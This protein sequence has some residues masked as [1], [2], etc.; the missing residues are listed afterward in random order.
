[1]G[2]LTAIALLTSLLV[3]SAKGNNETEVS[4]CLSYNSKEY[5]TSYDTFNLADAKRF[6]NEHNSKLA[7]ISSERLMELLKE[8]CLSSSS[9]FEYPFMNYANSEVLQLGAVAKKYEGFKWSFV[10]ASSEYKALCETEKCI[11]ERFSNEICF[12]ISTAKY[13]FVDAE[14]YCINQGMRLAS[15]HS[16]EEQNF[17]KERVTG[18]TW[19]GMAERPQV[20]KKLFKWLDGTPIDYTCWMK[21]QPNHSGGGE[22]CVEIRNSEW[23]DD[24]CSKK[25]K[26][27]CRGGAETGAPH[28]LNSIF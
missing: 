6:C 14:K 20:G 3:L 28:A 11:G 4:S 12:L 25:N 9:Y 5:F 24:T 10:D 23:N 7:V 22:H 27:V 16:E 13:S 17:L 15:I 18:D 19:I 21:G 26:A 1:M 8:K 2:T